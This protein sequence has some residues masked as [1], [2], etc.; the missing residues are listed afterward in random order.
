MI[1][2]YY[3]KLKRSKLEKKV[4]R[5][6]TNESKGQLKA[7]FDQTNWEIFQ[8]GSRGEMTAVTNDYINFCVQLVV[9]TKEIKIYLNSKSYVTKVIKKTDML[10]S[11]I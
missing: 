5:T 10:S 8:E 1:P 6:W 7:C 4:I 11:S 3:K 9:P 2:V